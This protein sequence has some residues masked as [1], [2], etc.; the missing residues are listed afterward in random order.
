MS[1]KLDLA[2]TLAAIFVLYHYIKGRLDRLEKR[3]FAD[4]RDASLALISKDIDSLK[5]ITAPL[6]LLNIFDSNESFI[7]S[8]G[9][10]LTSLIRDFD[11]AEQSRVTKLQE[12][13]RIERAEL[14]QY[15]REH[16]DG[17]D[18]LPSDDLRSAILSASVAIALRQSTD[19]LLQAIKELF[20]DV[21]SGKMSINQAREKARESGERKNYE[22]L[23][24]YHYPHP[25][26]HDAVTKEYDKLLNWH[27]G[28]WKNGA[29]LR[30]LRELD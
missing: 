21:I 28:G 4:E 13:D 23:R 15:A 16:P 7:V 11:K 29:R 3:L 6:R 5:G 22:D 10:V 9:V 26:A 8:D 27:E 25:N 20:I 18:F 14:E 2:C 30:W 1:N 24:H 19:T 12:V 17:S